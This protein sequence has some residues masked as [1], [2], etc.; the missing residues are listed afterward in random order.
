MDQPTAGQPRLSRYG[1]GAGRAWAWA[2]P[3]GASGQRR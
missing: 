3:S 2:P 1:W